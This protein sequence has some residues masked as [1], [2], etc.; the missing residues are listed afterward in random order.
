MGFFDLAGRAAVQEVVTAL[1]AEP[2]CS[3]ASYSITGEL[4]QRLYFLM[5]RV[6]AALNTEQP[7]F[8]LLSVDVI[9]DELLLSIMVAKNPDDVKSAD[10]A[11]LRALGQ[12][13]SN[14]LKIDVCHALVAE[15]DTDTF[16]PKGAKDDG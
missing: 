15:Y 11:E 6:I 14:L 12:S 7:V 9:D 1:R 2:G 13:L 3:M 8:T 16:A 10:Y 5:F 4:Y